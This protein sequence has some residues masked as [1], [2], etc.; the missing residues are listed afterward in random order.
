M[1]ILN[2]FP[3]FHIKV[4]TEMTSFE[5]PTLL[6]QINYHDKKEV[7]LFKRVFKILLATNSAS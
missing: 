3:K 4:N 6:S 2:K 7:Y 5:G 1:Q